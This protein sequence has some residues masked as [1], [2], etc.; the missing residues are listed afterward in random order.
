MRQPSGS[1]KMKRY[2]QL[3]PSRDHKPP[4]FMKS[5]PIQFTRGMRSLFYALLLTFVM[6]GCVIRSST[7]GVKNLWRAESVPVFERGKSTERD[8]LS[9][10]WA[11][12]SGYQRGKPDIILLSG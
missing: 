10:P 9:A 6:A 1:L 5:I 3:E 2:P 11:A 12:I 4:G 7:Q 8:V